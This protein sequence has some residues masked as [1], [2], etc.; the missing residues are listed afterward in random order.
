MQN[1]FFWQNE[2]VFFQRILFG[3]HLADGEKL[4]F[5]AHRHWIKIFKI[6]TQTF[7]F[8][9]VAP[10]G[11]WWLLGSSDNMFWIAVA[12]S[13]I[14][15]AIYFYSIV[16]WYFDAWLIT[17][18]AVIDIEWRGIFHHLSSR[19][20]YGEINEVAWEKKGFYG[21]IF[22]Y[23]DM[24]IGLPSGNHVVLADAANPKETE[25]A[26]HKARDG[27]LYSQKMTNADALQEILID[28]V[29]NHITEHGIPPKK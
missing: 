9:L 6:S 1:H 4:L 19:L 11:L 25:I 10:W 17:D 24:S 29:Q 3:S 2:Y 13:V 7:F 5:I 12:W 21:T 14:A 18:T 22:N 26:I 28:I 27:F 15:L 20:D 16:D 8:G 23:G